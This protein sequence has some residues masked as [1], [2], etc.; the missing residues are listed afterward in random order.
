[1]LLGIFASR[2]EI[3]KHGGQSDVQNDVN[4]LALLTS[5]SFKALLSSYLQNRLPPSYISISFISR[6]CVSPGLSVTLKDPRPAIGLSSIFIG[7]TFLS[8][9]KCGI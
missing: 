9:L 5:V 4:I 7:I 8:T 3:L 2:H 1:M 6:T